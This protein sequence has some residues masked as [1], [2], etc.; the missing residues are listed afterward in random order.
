M[1]EKVLEGSTTEANGNE[2]PLK[3]VDTV[4]AQVIHGNIPNI[5]KIQTYSEQCD[6]HVG[7]VEP[8]TKITKR[9]I[10]EKNKTPK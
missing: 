9:I 10:T 7:V 6:I 3:R 4:S 2:S 5:A 8:F 1:K